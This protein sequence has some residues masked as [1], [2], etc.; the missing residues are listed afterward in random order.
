MTEVL[1]ARETVRTLLAEFRFDE[2]FEIGRL[3]VIR[4]AVFQR[5]QSLL[6]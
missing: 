5:R 1:S 6:E 4:V 2:R 3:V